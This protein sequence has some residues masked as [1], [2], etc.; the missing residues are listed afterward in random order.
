MYSLNILLLVCGGQVEK[1][2]RKMKEYPTAAGCRY[3]TW[4]TPAAAHCCWLLLLLCPGSCCKR[5]AL[6][7]L[8]TAGT[9]LRRR[10]LMLEFLTCLR[11]K[12]CNSRL[13]LLKFP[14]RPV[15]T[16]RLQIYSGVAMVYFHITFGCLVQ[17]SS[18]LP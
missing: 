12:F 3:H 14:A 9:L 13:P 15:S 8:R 11:I 7:L 18:N 6:W 16:V 10:F 4:T 1:K 17:S 2:K 5:E